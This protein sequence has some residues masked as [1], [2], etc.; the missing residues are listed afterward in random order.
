MADKDRVPSKTSTDDSLLDFAA[1]AVVMKV[2]SLARIFYVNEKLIRG[3]SDF[4]NSAMKREWRQGCKRVVDLPDHNCEI[5]NLYVNWLYSGRLPVQHIEESNLMNNND[6]QYHNL[7]KAYVLGDALLD[8]DFKDAVVDAIVNEMHIQ[9]QGNVYFF[10]VRQI[11]TFLYN[12]T[13]SASKLRQLLVQRIARS[14]NGS[15]L[16]KEDDDPAFLLDF[17]RAAMHK[18]KDKETTISATARCAFHEHARGKCVR[19]R[20]G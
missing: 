4:F 6:K 7:F 1:P 19:T 20:F 13:T 8:S 14:S 11:R 5:F 15:E 17:A 18:D 16:L 10:P 9:H 2:G 12:S 3:S